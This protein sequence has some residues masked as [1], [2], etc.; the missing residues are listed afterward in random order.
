VRSAI[1]LDD[2]ASMLAEE[3]DDKRT[4][5]ML[6]PEFGLHDLRAT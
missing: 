6:T 4:D 1:S 5:W 3:I 2:E